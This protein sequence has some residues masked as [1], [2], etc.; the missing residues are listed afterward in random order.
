MATVREL[1]EALEEL[2]DTEAGT[3]VLIASQPAWPF[4]NRIK[5]LE[6]VEFVSDHPFEFSEDGPSDFTECAICGEHAEAEE[7]QMLS[8]IYVVE[9][10]QVGYLP[11]DAKE[12]FE[13]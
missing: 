8:K 6:V 10:D 7:H 5:S 13:R 12:V 4:E 9:G 3:E 11:S 2:L 1:Y